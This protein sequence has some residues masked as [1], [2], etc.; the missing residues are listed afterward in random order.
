MRITTIAT[1]LEVETASNQPSATVDGERIKLTLLA[2]N[3]QETSVA[4]GRR[5]A[6]TL[7]V[8]IGKMAN[9]LPADRAEPLGQQKE[10]LRLKDPSFQVGINHLGA[11]ILAI[12]PHKFPSLEFEFNVE[13]VS[14]LIEGLK[15]VS[16]IPSV[17]S[18]TKH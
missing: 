15:T 1:P 3:G 9:S 2:E 18:R 4:L 6:L 12:R 5:E 13:A 17:R 7:I 11:V 14:K 8:T 16:T 10:V